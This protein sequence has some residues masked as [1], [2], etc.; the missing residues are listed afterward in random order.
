MHDLTV[1]QLIE[2]LKQYPEDAKVLIHWEQFAYSPI[3]HIEYYPETNELE[4]EH[5]N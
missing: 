5:D 1:K 2:M 3:E 4:I